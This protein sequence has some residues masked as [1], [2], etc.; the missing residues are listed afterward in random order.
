MPM[1][2]EERD[3]VGSMPAPLRE[4]VEA[5]LAAGNAIVEVGCS[6]P[7]PPAG[8]FLKLARPVTTRPRASSEGVEFY[9]RNSSLYSG[10]FADAK[11]WYFVL[12]PPL[13]EP[14]EPDMDAIRAAVNTPTATTLPTTAAS[15][16]AAS[17]VERFRN[18]M[19]IDYE[20]WHDGVGYEV[21][22]IAQATPAERNQIEQLLLGR[23]ARDWRDVEALAA[24]GTPPA[25]GVLREAL[26][27]ADDEIR[28]AV[29]Q[30][31]PDLVDQSER[32]VALVDALAGAEFGSGLTQALGEVEDFHPPAVIDALFR[33]ALR[34]DGQ[35]A[36]HFAAMLTYL[37][38]KAAE[39]FE[40][41]QRDFFLK[42]NA[43][44]RAERESCF[45]E[46]CDHIG[47]DADELLA[48]L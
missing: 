43:D 20:K 46:L 41:E 47:F 32:T 40:W 25:L 24:L 33:G 13:P 29:L 30:H 39:P 28:V 8:C 16:P 4:L 18:S 12:E 34:R 6:F 45:R 44:D 42:F 37:Y 11:R 9:A 2:P 22:L 35:V 23:G 48:R 31:A 5:E 1:S 3:A 38:G 36:V 21:G 7:A 19:A 15:V 27:N 17:L 14:A 10:E 26:Q